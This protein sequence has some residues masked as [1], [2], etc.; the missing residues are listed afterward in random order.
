MKS[1]NVRKIISFIS[2]INLVF[3]T[4]L[5]L[6]FALPVYAEDATPAAVV[7]VSPTPDPTPTEESTAEPTATPTLEPT[8]TPTLEPTPD[9]EPA[10]TATPTAEPTIEPDAQPTTDPTTEPVVTPDP[11]EIQNNS[12]PAEETPNQPTVTTDK[13][14][15]APTD[16]VQIAGMF[17]LANTPYTSTVTS[18]T[19]NYS[20]IYNLTTDGVGS[21]M[22]FLPLL[23]EYRPNYEIAVTDSSQEVIAST[24]FTDSPPPVCNGSTFD[25]FSL[26]SVN[27]QG[28]WKVTG[29]YDQEIVNN[30]YGLSEFGCKTFRLSNAVATGSF[31]DQTFSYSL[32]NEAGET[33]AQNNGLS[34]GTRQNHFEAQ[35]DI[36]SAISNQQT[37]LSISISPDRGDGA[38]M[39][40]L[41]FADQSD[42]IHVYFDDYVSGFVET[43]IDT[44]NRNKSYT[45]K[46]VMDFVD[47]PAND[48]VKIYIDGSLKHTGTSWEDYYRDFEHNPTRTVDSLLLRAGGTGGVPGNNGKGF[49]FDNFSLSSS[50]VVVPVCGNGAIESDEQCDDG[51]LTDGDGCNSSCQTEN[52]WTCLGQ[53]SVCTEGKIDWCHCEPNGNCQ[54]LNLP[55]SALQ[56]AGHMSADGN[57]LHAGDNLGVCSETKGTIEIKKIISPSDTTNWNFGIDAGYTFMV[58]GKTD[59]YSSGQVEVTPGNHN[60]FEQV[61]YNG[62]PNSGFTDGSKY[63][64]SVV[65]KDGESVVSTGGPISV[66]Y[67]VNLV[68]TGFNVSAGQHIICTFTNTKKGTIEIK[69]VISPSDSTNWNFG[70]D[71]G[72]TFWDTQKTDG[73]TS[74]QIGVIPGRHNVFEQVG[75]NGEPINGF[76][77]GSKYSSSVVCKDGETIVTTSGPASLPYGNNLVTPEFNVASDQHIVCTFTNSKFASISGKKFNDLNG[78]GQ[79]DLNELG[80]QGWVI[81]LDK[82]A[83]GSVDSSATTD[84]NGNY[85]FTNLLAGSYRVRETSKTGWVQKTIEPTDINLQNGSNV[86]GIDFGNQLQW[87]TIQ[88]QKVICDAEQY[89]PNGTQGAINA[90][91]AQNWVTNSNGHCRLADNWNFQ[92]ALSGGS[93][94]AF[95]TNTSALG[96]PWTTFTGTTNIASENLGSKIEIRE[97]FPNNT[98]VPFSNSASNVSAEIYCTGDG[99]NYDNWEWINNPQYGTTYNCVAFNAPK[100]GKITVIKQ[101]DTNNDD[102]IEN[103]NATN[104]TWDIRNGEQNIATGQTRTLSVGSYTIS[105][106]QK[107]DYQLKDWSCSNNTRGTTNSIPVTLNSNDDITCTITNTRKTGSI[108]VCKVILDAEGNMVDGSVLPNTIFSLSG[109]D[110]STSQGVAAGV[111]GT[112]TFSTPLTFNTKLFGAGSNNAICATYSN[113]IPGNYYYGQESSLSSVWSTPKYNDGASVPS[114]IDGNFFEYSGQ[115]FDDIFNNDGSRNTISDGHIVLNPGQQ[116]RTLIVLNQYKFGSISGY[117]WNDVN[118]DRELTCTYQ[119]DEQ[120]VCEEKLSKWTIFIDK[121]GDKVFDDGEVSTQTLGSDGYHFSNLTPGTY[122]ICEV[123]KDGWTNSYPVESTCQLVTVT[124]GNDSNDVNFGNHQVDAE[125]FI[126]RSNNA[127]S[128]LTPGS[129]VE[130][131]ITIKVEGNDIT[132]LQLTDLLPKGFSFSGSY[133]VSSTLRGPITLTSAPEYHSP[134]IWDLGDYEKGDTITIKYL[135]DIS[136]DTEPGIYPDLASATANDAYEQGLTFLALGENSEYVETNFVGTD[137]E[138][139]KNQTQGGNYDV[140]KKVEGTVLGAT[141][142]L[143]ATGASP[144]WL[145]LAFVCLVY[146]IR[147]I[148]SGNK[149]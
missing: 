63:S 138:I 37:G 36:A 14:D 108:R 8:A 104:W 110:I 49:I 118:G 93:F 147:F 146:G 75:Y 51:N 96:T 148:K 9:I 15:Y 116:N 87:V 27:G 25:S 71:A 32:G 60:V 12:P 102:E 77:D 74:G 145:M 106:D 70:I 5:P 81:N 129:S 35:F 117:K 84:V 4:F 19:D 61:G 33:S 29:S 68:S 119:N 85:S 140:E 54:T 24:T 126:S 47:G 131:T 45:I 79:K 23:N 53:P 46:F 97:V 94:G 44:L 1:R 20:N 16:T 65:C 43:E 39:S 124:A 55:S 40:Y 135:A 50:T 41:R 107:S 17:F 149:K 80:I 144:F 95:Q 91:T 137:V 3:Q 58:T 57:P 109:L 72:Y 141:T 101:V 128:A 22:Y 115:L 31:G 42:K 127:S 100:T 83:D 98:Y 34:G 6:T 26:G 59:G 21:F 88:S 113:L 2:S 28:G 78:N 122:S 143:P 123:Q 112:T 73:Y 82:G 139:V 64:S 105:E 121:D 114:K 99:A 111:L 10:V 11:A 38:R 13:A 62:E 48:I 142:S 86:T 76:T 90:S 103:T 52:K 89:L 56:N 67:G 30:T 69:K 130:H 132:N 18:E 7:D 134:G 92:W 120:G 125:L 66:P 133:S 136:G